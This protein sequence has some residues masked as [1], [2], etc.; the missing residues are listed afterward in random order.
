MEMKMITDNLTCDCGCKLF[1]DFRP[2]T[3]DYNSFMV[4]N[5]KESL[6]PT[7]HT[8]PVA[9]CLSCGKILVPKASF[10]G[11]NILDEE[12]QLY[13]DLLN[14]AKNRNALID[15]LELL[16]KKCD[17]L[18]LAVIDLHRSKDVPVKATPVSE[19]SPEDVV[20]TGKPGSGTRKNNKK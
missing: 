6:K 3:L 12:V 15:Q 16:Q 5:L 9:Q 14:Y 4:W 8:I 17:D 2:F 20:D 10:Q 19:E 18:K 11:K 13:S 1:N 7:K